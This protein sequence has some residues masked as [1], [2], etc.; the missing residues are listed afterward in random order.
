MAIAKFPKDIS[1]DLGKIMMEGHEKELG[2]VARDLLGDI[3]EFIVAVVTK[4][5]NRSDCNQRNKSQ[6]KAIL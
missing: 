1:A 6:K 3:A 4:G 2:G 5:S